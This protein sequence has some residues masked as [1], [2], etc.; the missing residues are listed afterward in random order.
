M[1]DGSLPRLGVSTL[2]SSGSEILLVQRGKAPA[3]GLW[4]LPGGSVESGE[5]LADAAV[6]EVFEETHLKLDIV[7][8]VEPAEAITP[9][10][11]FVIHVFVAKLDHKPDI[12]AGDDAADVGWFTMDEI[13]QFDKDEAMTPGTAKRIARILDTL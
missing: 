10:Y 5:Q 11:H 6:R 8:F 12:Q 7:K 9:D 2:V 13:R 4:S 1:H 3:Q